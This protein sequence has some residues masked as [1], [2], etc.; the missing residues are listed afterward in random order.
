MTDTH[1]DISGSFLF[2]LIVLDGKELSDTL[3]GT[4]ET[5]P[6]TFKHTAYTIIL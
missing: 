4:G 5:D 1:V 6:K 3:S 2:R